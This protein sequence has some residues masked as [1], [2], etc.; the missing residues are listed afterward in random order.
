LVFERH[1][2]ENLRLYS[3][4][5]KRG[6]RVQLRASLGDFRTWRVTKVANG[7]AT[8]VDAEGSE[9]KQ[10]VIDLVVVKE[11]GEPIF[12]GIRRLE[13]IERGGDKP[14]HIVLNAENHHAL[15]TLSYLYEGRIDCIYIDP[16]YNTGVDTTRVTRVTKSQYSPG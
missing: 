15:Q 13:S 14:F 11:F 1:F 6:V 5:V 10:A 9:H 12:P 2:P 7:R 4:P 8:L 16:P 3:H